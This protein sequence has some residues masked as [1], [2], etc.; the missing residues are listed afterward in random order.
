M[1][2]TFLLGLERINDKCFTD[3]NSTFEPHMQIV[4]R[5]GIDRVSHSGQ[6]GKDTFRERRGYVPQTIRCYI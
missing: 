2:H 1:E 3:A 6:G 4:L 5:E